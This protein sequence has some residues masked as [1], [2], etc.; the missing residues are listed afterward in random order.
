MLKGRHKY[1]LT[2][3]MAVVVLAN[4]ACSDVTESSYSSA[5]DAKDRGAVERGWVPAL[6]NEETFNIREIHNIDTNETWGT[7]QFTKGKNPVDPS[8]LTAVSSEEVG[9]RHFREPVVNWWPSTL[10][11]PI[12][13]LKLSQAGFQI[14]TDSEARLFFAYNV[15]SGTGYFWSVE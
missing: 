2:P 12:A 4:V 7:F 10:R 1:L 9:K 14:Y 11:V 5:S 8:K 13:E 15:G 3:L 6:L